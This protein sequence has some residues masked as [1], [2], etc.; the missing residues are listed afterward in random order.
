V[1]EELSWPGNWRRTACA[2]HSKS[3][4]DQISIKVFAA[5]ELVPPFK[6]HDSVADGSADLYHGAEYFWR[7]KSKAF[8]FFAA[9]PFDLT[10]TEMNA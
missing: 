2:A 1:A 6:S 9:V 3:S 10:A 8:N 5:G 4:N 7:G